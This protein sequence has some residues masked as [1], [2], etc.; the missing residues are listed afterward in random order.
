MYRVI[1]GNDTG[2]TRKLLTECG[3]QPRALFVCAH[4]QRIPA[5]CSAY[6]IPT[7]KAI[8]YEDYIHELIEQ[9]FYNLNE[10]PVYIDEL[11]KFTKVLIP[12]LAG[13]TLTNE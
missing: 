12:Y 10:C 7:V 9:Q 6:G 13:Y 5:K 4:P 8:G 2:K 3:K 11:E 1:D